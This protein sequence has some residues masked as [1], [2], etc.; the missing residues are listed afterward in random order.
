VRTASTLPALSVLDI[1][2]ASWQRQRALP[3]V[4]QRFH[5]GYGDAARQSWA[6]SPKPSDAIGTASTCSR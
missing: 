1:L 5:G 6:T 2:A 3:T 4:S